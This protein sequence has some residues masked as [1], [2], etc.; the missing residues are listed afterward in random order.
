M[1]HI[2]AKSGYLYIIGCL[3]RPGTLTFATELEHRYFPP[4]DTELNDLYTIFQLNYCEMPWYVIEVPN[5]TMKI[6]EKL[7]KE[8]KLKLVNG[9]PTQIQGN[10][11]NKVNGV[12]EF[13]LLCS[14]ESCF[15]LETDHQSHDHSLDWTEMLRE[16][17]QNVQ[18]KYTIN[19][20]SN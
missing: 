13:N 20:A 6:L 15:T 8:C 12:N 18:H 10:D 16:E 14:A 19:N 1:D 17:R 4:S 7:A 11:G 3:Y 5:H 2:Y 9:K